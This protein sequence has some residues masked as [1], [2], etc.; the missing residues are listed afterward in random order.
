MGAAEQEKFIQIREVIHKK[1]PRLAKWIPRP[2]VSYLRRVIHEDEINYIMRK[3]KDDHGLDF[4]D[5]LLGELGVEVVLEGEEHIPLDDSV[6]FA[7]NHPLGGL[8]GV[9]FMQAIGQYRQDVKFIVNDILLNVTNLQPLFVGVNKV[10]GQNK[11]NMSAVEQAYA[12]DLALLVFPA[13]LVS[14]KINGNIQDLEWKK[15][16]VSKA[17]KYK[18]DVI[19]VYIDGKNSNFFYNLANLRRKVGMKANIEMLYLSDEMFAQ[20]GQRVK[21]VIG[22][23]IAYTDFDKSKSERAWAQDVRARVYALAEGETR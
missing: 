15:S 9:A 2:L 6:I 5:A 1:S 4:V 18:K 21:I 19:P 10:G 7:S 13:G 16:F 3:Y 14:R 11:A 23:R 12:S 22:K 17:K 8:D 20:R